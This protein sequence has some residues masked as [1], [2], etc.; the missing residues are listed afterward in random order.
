MAYKKFHWVGK[1]TIHLNL[2]KSMNVIAPKTIKMVQ[3]G[4]KD[5]ENNK[6]ARHLNTI[7]FLQLWSDVYLIAKEDLE[8]C[9]SELL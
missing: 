8:N 7:L 1:V 2:K 9:A 6:F 4:F 5:T 3:K